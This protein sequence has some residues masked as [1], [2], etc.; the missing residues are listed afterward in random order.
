M[1]YQLFCALPVRS[2]PLN[3]IPLLSLPGGIR[4]VK[5]FDYAGGVSGKIHED[6]YRWRLRDDKEI[7]DIIMTMVLSGRL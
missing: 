4:R 7:L 6:L 2:Y 1:L 5:V 3:G